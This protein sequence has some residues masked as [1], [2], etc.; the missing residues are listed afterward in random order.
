MLDLLNTLNIFK[1]EKHHFKDYIPI[2]KVQSDI[3]VCSFVGYGEGPLIYKIQHFEISS[4]DHLWTIFPRYC[5]FISFCG[6]IN[7]CLT[8]LTWMQVRFIAFFSWMSSFLSTSFR[9]IST[10]ISSPVLHKDK[11][12]KSIFKINYACNAKV[13][14]HILICIKLFT[15]FLAHS[16]WMYQ[17][18][19]VYDYFIPR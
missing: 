7:A 18:V 14:V 19:F 17:H 6:H 13:Y 3:L 15:V 12:F 10:V 5:N 2:F 4:H 1:E 9:L 16:V 8:V 11:M